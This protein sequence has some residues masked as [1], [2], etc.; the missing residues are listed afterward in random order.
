VHPCSRPHKVLTL[1]VALDSNSRS[2]RLLT[3][4]AAREELLLLVA[5]CTP[6]AFLLGADQGG[7]KR[8]ADSAKVVSAAG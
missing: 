2:M 4:S 3:C 8:P 7:L 6:S 5:C 1:P